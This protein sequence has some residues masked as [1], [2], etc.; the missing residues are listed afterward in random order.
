VIEGVV[1]CALIVDE[2]MGPCLL[3]EGVDFASAIGCHGRNMYV[4]DI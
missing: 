3:E 4:K 2:D 1:L